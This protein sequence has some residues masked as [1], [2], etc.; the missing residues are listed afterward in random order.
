MLNK[1]DALCAER[2]RL[3]KRGRPWCPMARPWADGAGAE[4]WIREV[5]RSEELSERLETEVFETFHDLLT[6]EDHRARMDKRIG[7]KDFSGASRAAQRLGSDE[8]SI[9]KACVV[10]MAN[11][12]KALDRLDAVETSGRQDLGQTLC[13][14]HWML[15]HD[16]MEDATR[17]TLAAASETMA[18][19]DTE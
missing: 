3:K 2:D 7:A 10:A 5:W 8:L 1:I 4:R 17:L 15:Q 9:V 13:R 6:R 11:E 18:L 16:R 14:I 12:T 19:Q